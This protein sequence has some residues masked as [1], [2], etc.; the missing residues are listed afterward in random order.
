MTQTP[1]F[2]TFSQMLDGEEDLQGFDLTEDQKL[3]VDL[4][5]VLRDDTERVSIP[6]GFVEETAKLIN[7]RYQ[8]LSTTEKLLDTSRVHLME[9]LFRPSGLV[10]GLGVAARGAGLA[11]ASFTALAAY[12]GILLAF[13]LLWL[14]LEQKNG[15]LDF[16]DGGPMNSGAQRFAG[17]LGL[18]R[19]L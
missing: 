13:S 6:H 1:E 2:D 10:K 15:T 4:R 18:D 8:S 11:A 5:E 16:S 7:S 14:A 12:G 17:V 9:S 3:L 19:G